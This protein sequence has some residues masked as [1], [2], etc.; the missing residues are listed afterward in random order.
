MSR[1]PSSTMPE[2]VTTRPPPEATEEVGVGSLE[3]HLG[4]QGAGRELP[5]GERLAVVE[6]RLHAK[7][8]VHAHDLGGVHGAVGEGGD[9]A[10]VDPLA[11]K[12][13]GDRMAGA[14]GGLDGR[15]A[16]RAEVGRDLVAEHFHETQP[17]QVRSVTAVGAGEDVAAE[18]RGAARPAVTGGAAVGQSGA[19]AAVLA[20]FP[21][22][23]QGGRAQPLPQGE[24]ALEELAS[25][26][27]RAEGVARDDER[28]RS[29]GHHVAPAR[30]NLLFQ[31]LPDSFVGGVRRLRQVA[32]LG[33]GGGGQTA[34]GQQDGY[35]A[36]G[37]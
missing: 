34:N 33:P 9:P 29:R 4:V 11:Q 25:T 2:G 20:D 32:E 30:S 3:P 6:E 23:V 13:A 10:V 35:R 26:A 5:D 12:R 15:G 17:E 7:V 1:A 36:P 18:S 27:D 14:L 19:D 8:R 31:R 22:P 37:P 16:D 21:R 24:L 28:R